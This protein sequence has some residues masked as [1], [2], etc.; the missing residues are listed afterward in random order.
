MG[1]YNVYLKYMYINLSTLRNIGEKIGVQGKSKH[2]LLK[3]ILNKLGV[4]VSTPTPTPPRRV[5]MVNVLTGKILKFDSTYAA[6]KYFNKS[7]S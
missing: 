4:E 6:G 3:A 2:E 1:M 5:E 7:N